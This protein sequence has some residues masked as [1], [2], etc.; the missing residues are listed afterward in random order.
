MSK[1]IKPC[2]W[3]GC[4]NQS[5]VAVETFRNGLD[6]ICFRVLS[7][8]CGATGPVATTEAAAIELWNAFPR[9]EP[10]RTR[11][12]M[13]V[14]DFKDFCEHQSQEEFDV[15]PPQEIREP[16]RAGLC[17]TCYYGLAQNGWCHILETFPRQ[18]QTA[19][20][21]HETRLESDPE[22]PA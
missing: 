2:M 15:N 19:C 16:A 20:L 6:E 21:Y 17:P 3:E 14:C 7:N 8:G 22:T 12:V 5:D 4:A 18:P 13:F 1:P 11:V 10:A 9:P